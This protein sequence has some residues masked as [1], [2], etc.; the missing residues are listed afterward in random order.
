MDGRFKL[1][2]KT[3]T[4]GKRKRKWGSGSGQGKAREATVGGETMGIAEP[5]MGTCP[6]WIRVYESSY[7]MP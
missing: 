1:V 4:R 3:R 6:H 7:D 2:Y 5:R